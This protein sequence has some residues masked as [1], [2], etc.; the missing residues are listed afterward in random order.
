MWDAVE[1]AC[2]FLVLVA[3]L[4]G[5]TLLTSHSCLRL[6][7]ACSSRCVAAAAVAAVVVA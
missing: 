6:V 1:Q 5:T 2:C 7:I 3:M 4:V